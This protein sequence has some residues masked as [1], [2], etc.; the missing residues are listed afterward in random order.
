MSNVENKNGAGAAD[1]EGGGRQGPSTP[2]TV[3]EYRRKDGSRSHYR[4]QS[5]CQS[6]YQSEVKSHSAVVDVEPA[7]DAESED[8][9]VASRLDEHEVDADVVVLVKQPDQKDR[10]APLGDSEH[11]LPVVGSIPDLECNVTSYANKH[12]AKVA[13][14]A[15]K[16]SSRWIIT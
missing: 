14:V 6:P 9:V 1:T 16:S 7:G 12:Y 2:C 3:H 5:P 15:A 11:G 10:F 4:Y 8:D 13:D